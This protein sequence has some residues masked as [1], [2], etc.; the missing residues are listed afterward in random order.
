M[1]SFLVRRKETKDSEGEQKECHRKS[2]Q[3]WQKHRECVVENQEGK[4]I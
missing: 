3:D 2:Q 4:K 1:T